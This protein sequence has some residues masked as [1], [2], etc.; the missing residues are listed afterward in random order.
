LKDHLRFE[1]QKSN[2]EFKDR[3]VQ[4]YDK[5]LTLENPEQVLERFSSQVQ[6]PIDASDLEDIFVLSLFLSL[7][8]SFFISFSLSI[9]IFFLRL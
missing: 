8:L 7:S 3:L 2:L 9:F 6:K 5:K 1:V 4:C